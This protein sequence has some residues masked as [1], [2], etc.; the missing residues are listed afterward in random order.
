MP[1]SNDFTM[2]QA[3]FIYQPIRGHYREKQF[4]LP[5]Q[6]FYIRDWRFVRA[7]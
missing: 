4:Y 3:E 2:V 5:E 1:P 6:D 7:A